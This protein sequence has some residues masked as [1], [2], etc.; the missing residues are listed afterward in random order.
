MSATALQRG[1]SAAER[2]EDRLRVTADGTV[3]VRSGKVEYGQGIRTGF[4]TIVAREL[5]VPLGRVQVELGETDHCPWDMGTFGS[6]STATEGMAL[7]AAA[8]HARTLLKRRAAAHLHLDPGKLTL[9]DGQIMAADGRAVSFV[10]LVGPYG[11]L[12]GAV[13]PY[14]P[15]E[16]TYPPGS[17]AEVRRLEAL[18]IVLGRPRFANDVR[19]PGLLHAQVVHGPVL[20]ASLS[21]LDERMARTLPGIRAIVREREFVAVVAEREAQAAAAARVLLPTWD[22]PSA[23]AATTEI[24]LRRD[25]AVEVAFASAVR[26]LTAA[27]HVPHIA[28]AAI[29]PSVAV[30]DVRAEGA[31]LYVA[32]QRPFALRDDAA[33]LLGLAPAAVHVHPQAM[34]GMFGR[35]SAHDAALEAARVSR[36]VGAPVLVQ[37]SR[38][39]E[40]RLSPHRPTLDAT[41][42]A[43]LDASGKIIAWRYRSRTN[44]H[45]YGTGDAGA[46]AGEFLA[47]TSGRN[48]VPPYHLGRAEV[49]LQ[50]TPGAVRTGALRSLAAAPN[51]FA[52]ESFIDELAHASGQD[53]LA[54]RLRHT[55]DPRLAGVIAMVRERSDWGRHARQPGRGFG[56]ACTVYHGTYVAMVVEVRALPGEAPHLERVWC[57]IDPGEVI[58]PDGAR[59]QTEG[60]IQQAA[61]WALLEQLAHQQGRV[62]TSTW[63]DYPIAT[64]RDAPRTIEVVLVPGRAAPTG[65]GEPGAVPVAAALANALFDASGRRIRALPL[66]TRCAGAGA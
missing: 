20:H 51:A 61:S 44:P 34:G 19:L 18:D 30:A 43:A 11:P 17:F 42:Q 5:C 35:G 1:M 48:A 56:A 10:E 55:D 26:T 2:L 22:T 58:W 63:H 53:T 39:D 28:H 47:M 23:V 14:A 24:V 25:A 64:F 49:L 65:V 7:R 8:A 21:S 37:W 29:C 66:F 3:I 38:E 50:I 27:Y 40:F 52:I 16:A 41:V 60:A 62:T 36:A 33:S 15:D 54:F 12:S 45:T 59:N 46:P 57:A 6:L 4:A 31:H 9:R 32:A 13:P